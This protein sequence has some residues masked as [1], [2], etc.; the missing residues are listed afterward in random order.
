MKPIIQLQQPVNNVI[1]N[2]PTV[3]L[4]AKYNNTYVEETL[5]EFKNATILEQ[6][7][8]NTN[9]ISLSRIPKIDDFSSEILST[10]WNWL[11][12]K[13]GP[14]Y[15]LVT[16][17]GNLTI[18]VPSTTSFNDWDSL[19]ESPKMIQQVPDG[20]FEVEIKINDAYASSDSYYHYG[21]IVYFGE[22]DCH[23]FG[24]YNNNSIVRLEKS[25]ETIS[26]MYVTGNNSGYL[27][28]TRIGTIYSYYHKTNELDN[29]VL[30][31]TVNRIGLCSVG[32]FVKTWNPRNVRLIVDYFKITSTVCNYYANGTRIA[33]PINLDGIATGNEIINWTSIEPL[34]TN[35]IVECAINNDILTVPSD[36]DFIIA[37]NDQQLSCISVN[38]DLTG[39]FLWIREKLQTNSISTP[40]LNKLEINISDNK[41]I[42]LTFKIDRCSIFGSSYE[43]TYTAS[44]I[45]NQIINWTPTLSKGNWYWKIASS[46][47]GNSEIYSVEIA[48]PNNTLALH[49]YENINLNFSEFINE[50]ALYQY[51]NPIY[52]STN[53]IDSYTKILLHFNN[54]DNYILDEVGH[55]ATGNITN[56][57]NTIYPNLKN[58][59]YSGYFDNNSFIISGND[60]SP[61]TY[62]FTLEMWVY[63]TV[64]SNSKG[65][66]ELAPRNSTDGFYFGF[67][68]N[69]IQLYNNSTGS[70]MGGNVVLNKWQHI[71]VV[72][73]SGLITFYLDGISVHSFLCNHN[74][75]NTSCYI[76]GAYISNQFFNGY[77]D[78]LRYS[79]G[80]ARWTSNFT[81]SI[82]EYGSIVKNRKFVQII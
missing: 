51:Y 30:C 35:I 50:R 33:K 20:D 59:R 70:Q 21:L 7:V 32:M 62:D 76:G 14:T 53:K 55:S 45:N 5:D 15:S 10:D 12:P 2:Q 22:K 54:N 77:M 40:I 72:R 24:K 42:N 1:I 3:E 41:P 69:K 39:K 71:A 25:G 75:I 78:E 19:S 37:V 60:L 31:S 8:V 16:N 65:L 74:F 29:W 47:G 52:V 67:Y 17:A 64:L 63:P 82:L 57:S 13:A 80:I 66:F 34:E 44:C 26:N 43:Q 58:N 23:F 27:K 4:S 49:Q 48:I 18:E 9:G 38:D 6:I 61:G 81:P 79:V 46:D 11:M 28:V 56:Y 73:N 68:N 36:T